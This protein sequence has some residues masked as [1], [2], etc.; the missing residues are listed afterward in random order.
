LPSLAPELE[1]RQEA[2]PYVVVLADRQGADLVAVHHGGPDVHLEVDGAEEARP[3]VHAGGWSERRYQQRAEGAWAQNAAEV[4]GQVARLVSAVDARFVAV[5]G[6]V[7]AVQLLRDELPDEVAG[8]IAEVGGSRAA[9]G[10]PGADPADVERLRAEVVARDTADLL[11]KLAEEVGQHDRGRAG[12]ADTID[13]LRAAQVLSLLVHD[14]EEDDRTAWFGTD[15][16][17]VGRRRSELDG[18]ADEPREGRLVDALIRSA[19]AGG[20]GVRVLPS[21]TDVPDGVAAILRWA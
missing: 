16:L 12:A 13:A 5:A 14:D 4:A 1:R 2:V 20:A 9:D 21:G 6:D 10:T 18:L 7:R 3:K 17:M 11:G 8:L 19:L 15:P